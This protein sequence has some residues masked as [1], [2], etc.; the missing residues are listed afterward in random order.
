MWCHDRS[1]STR[2]ALAR[3]HNAWNWAPAFVPT[4]VFDPCPPLLANAVIGGVVAIAGQQWPHVIAEIAHGAMARAGWIYESVLGGLR[5]VSNG[6]L[7]E[8]PYYT[9]TI[10]IT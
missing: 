1:T 2:M 8:R 5:C 6:V 9:Y 3:I 7:S 10:I 4:I